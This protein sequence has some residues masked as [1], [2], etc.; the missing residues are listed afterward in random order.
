LT[1]PI[2]N[3]QTSSQLLSE[4]LEQPVRVLDSP[5]T[6]KVGELDAQDTYERT[7][8]KTG[9]VVRAVLGDDLFGDLAFRQRVAQAARDLAAS[10]ASF[11]GCQENDS[12][13]KDLWTLGYGGRMQVRKF[14]E[15][16][17]LGSPAV[18]LKDIFEHG[19]RY[20]FECASAMM[21][22]FH[23]AI[24]DT[25]GD[26]IFD[27][28]FTEPAYLKIFRWELK[29]NDYLELE[30]I[31]QGKSDLVPGSHYYYKNPDASAANSAFG[32]ENVVYLGS[33]NGQRMFYAHGVCGAKG[34]YLVSEDE[35]IASL[36]SLRRMGAT[37]AP[38]RDTFT[39]SIDAKR[40]AAKAQQLAA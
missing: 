22:L 20:G 14:L 26:T 39:Y 3:L 6:G 7:D 32:G 18:A 40:L 9:K 36:S 30:Q 5:T 38:F 19:R 16:G 2:R 35:L 21:V 34:T 29:D 27:K 1:T 23:K 15:A 31:E 13:N 17:K 12:V 33:E 8:P 10:G 4:L 24:L 11:S 28:M 25:V 37:T